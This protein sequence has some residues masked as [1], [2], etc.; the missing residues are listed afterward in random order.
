MCLF[1]FLRPSTHFLSETLLISFLAGGHFSIFIRVFFFF[2]IGRNG[3]I[4][5]DYRPRTT[6]RLIHYYK[7]ALVSVQNRKPMFYDDILC[8]FSTNFYSVAGS[9][10]ILIFARVSD[11]FAITSVAG[12]LVDIDEK[13]RNTKELLI[14]FLYFLV[15][16]HALPETRNRSGPTDGYTARIV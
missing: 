14:F 15:S 3:N 16:S 13:K 5:G 2:T 9:F 7:H 4:N 6:R 1:F 12:G 11:G 10:T 8:Y